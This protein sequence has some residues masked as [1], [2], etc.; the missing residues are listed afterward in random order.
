[1]AAGAVVLLKDFLAAS[2]GR[3]VLGSAKYADRRRQFQRADVGG[4]VLY[5]VL[6]ILVALVIWGVI[7]LFSGSQGG[8][9]PVTTTTQPPTTTSVPT[10]TTTSGGFQ[11]PTLPSVITL[12]SLPSTITLPSL[13]STITLPSLP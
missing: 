1:M 2:D 9:P 3:L 11:L 7:A 4:D 8:A 5:L 13:P 6:A 10:T 12:P